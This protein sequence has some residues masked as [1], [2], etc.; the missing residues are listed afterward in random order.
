MIKNVIKHI[1][2]VSKHRWIVFKLCCKI[3]LPWRGLVHDLSKFSPTEFWESVRYYIGVDSPIPEARKIK[4]YSE[5]YL[6]HRG[7]N[8]HH[9]DYWIDFETRTVA[10]VIPYKYLAE[11]ICDNISAGMVYKGKN[12][13]PETQYE[14]WINKKD[15]GTVITNPKVDNF[16]TEVL[17]QVKE[18]G[19]DKTLTKK[20]LKSLYKKFCID[21]KTEYIYEFKGEWKKV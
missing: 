5:C 19:I 8:K 12:W 14:Y 15:K 11:L 2:T 16:I 21:D 10:P 7:R 4:G 20:N 18:N 3:G 13:S 1:K 6:H 9:L 17:Y